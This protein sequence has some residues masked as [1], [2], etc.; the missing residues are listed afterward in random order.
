[1]RRKWPR[2][3]RDALVVFLQYGGYSLAAGSIATYFALVF[4]GPYQLG[5]L[6]KLMFGGIVM[7]FSSGLVCKSRARKNKAEHDK[8]ASTE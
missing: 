6:M 8:T 2:R 4:L 1:M 7:F 5:W 3:K